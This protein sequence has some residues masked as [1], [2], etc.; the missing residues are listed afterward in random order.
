MARKLPIRSGILLSFTPLPEASVP[1]LPCLLNPIIPIY[2]V[3][4]PSSSCLGSKCCFCVLR[5][6]TESFVCQRSASTVGETLFRSFFLN[7][8]WILS[9]AVEDEGPPSY[10]VCAR[11]VAIR[12]RWGFHFSWWFALYCLILCVCDWK[13]NEG[14]CFL[15]WV[16]LYVFRLPL[17]HL[18]LFGCNNGAVF[19]VVGYVLLWVFWLDRLS[20]SGIRL[21]ESFQYSYCLRCCR[22]IYY[23]Y[24]YCYVNYC[25]LFLTLK[26]LSEGTNRI[27]P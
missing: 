16:C 1:S 26:T 3:I 20:L 22:L 5:V 2:H 10:N 27:K 19:R 8:V 17:P 13:H 9:L 15:C 4:S 24:Y 25:D 7:S 14:L 6:G 11:N 23:C 18:F 21:T 12:F